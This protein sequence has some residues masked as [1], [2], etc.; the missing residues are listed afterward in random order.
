MTGMLTEHRDV[1]F[2]QRVGGRDFQYFAGDHVANGAAGAHDW[3]GAH[4][5]T[6]IKLAIGT[7]GIA[8]G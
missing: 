6:A 7:L 2:G 1:H 4:Q 5:A 3:L 8:H